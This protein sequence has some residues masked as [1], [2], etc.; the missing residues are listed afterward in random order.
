MVFFNRGYTFEA[1]ELPTEAQF[2]PALYAGAADFDGDGHEDVFLSQNFFALQPEMPRMDAGRGLW[3][4]GDGSGQLL[5]VPGQLS[6]IKIYGE[7]RGAALSDFNRDGRMDL[8]VSQNGAE[9]K[10]YQNNSG[11]PGLRIRL[12][13]TGD[14]PSAVGAAVQVI[15]PNANSP[16]KEIHAGSGYWSQDSPVL[17]FGLPESPELVRI[18]WPGGKITESK[19]NPGSKEV[20]INM[21]GKIV[22]QF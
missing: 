21:D 10:L 12:W 3:L 22:S 20:V 11:K 18:R 19:L 6:G 17:L 5:P 13:G 7:Q 16:V 9:T 14:N 2:A 1:V 4:K 15:F 8:V